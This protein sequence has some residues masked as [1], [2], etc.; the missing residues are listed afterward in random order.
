MP[1]EKYHYD[2]NIMQAVMKIIMFTLCIISQMLSESIL[3]EL[4]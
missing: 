1:E 4:H 2:C 3:H